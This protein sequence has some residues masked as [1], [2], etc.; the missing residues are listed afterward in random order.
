VVGEIGT[1][2]PEHRAVL[3]EQVEAL[4]TELMQHLPPASRLSR[5]HLALGLVAMMY[6]GL[7]MA[8]ALRGSGLSDE[9]LRACRALGRSV[10]R[11]EPGQDAKAR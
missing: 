1:T 11:E 4:T 3:A 10:V 5:R 2:A 6:G 7:S 9:M 8:R